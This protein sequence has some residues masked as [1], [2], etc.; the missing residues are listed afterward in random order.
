VIELLDII[1]ESRDL[2]VHEW[3]FRVILKEHLANL[4]EWQRIY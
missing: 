3:N 2:E 1:E 4:L